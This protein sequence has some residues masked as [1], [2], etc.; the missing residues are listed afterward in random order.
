[1]QS[2]VCPTSDTPP[3][4]PNHKTFF[5]DGDVPKAQFHIKLG[6]YIKKVFVANSTVTKGDLLIVCFEK[7][8][9]KLVFAETLLYIV[10]MCVPFRVFAMLFND[11][12]IFYNTF[13]FYIMRLLRYTKI[14]GS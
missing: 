9:I 3:L 13:L 12:L 1:M 10:V 8:E 11:E 7:G 14:T 6:G 5:I 2:L 4:L